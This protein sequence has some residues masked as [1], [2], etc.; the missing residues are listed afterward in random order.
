MTWAPQAAQKTV[1]E[2]L[3]GDVALTTLLGGPRVFDHVPD[4]SVYPYVVI[5][6]K[7]MTDRGNTTFD[8]VALKYTINVWYQSPGRGDLQ[9]QRIQERVDQLLHARDICVEGWNVI[10]HRR[11]NVNILDEPDGVTK[12]GVQQFNLLLG[13]V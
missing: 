13:E 1:Y 5:Q 3:S 12:H 2:I 11:S 10:A 4:E 9:A 6:M 8:G 7:P